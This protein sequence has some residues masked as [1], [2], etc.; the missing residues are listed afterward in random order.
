M[1]NKFI[2]VILL[3]SSTNI[4][5]HITLINSSKT[6]QVFQIQMKSPKR[7][8]AR[9]RIHKSNDSIQRMRNLIRDPRCEKPRVDFLSGTPNALQ[10]HLFRGVPVRLRPREFNATGAASSCLSPARRGAATTGRGIKEEK[11]PSANRR[12]RERREAVY[13]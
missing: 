3:F 6:I 2:P 8:P 1:F 5:I 9:I 7:Q 12:G 13:V 10:F 4:N 11:I